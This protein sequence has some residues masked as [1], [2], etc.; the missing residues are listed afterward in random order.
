MSLKVGRYVEEEL[1]L[2][3]IEAGEVNVEWGLLVVWRVLAFM[4]VE[5]DLTM[6]LTMLERAG[7]G[8]SL[9][10]NSPT[11]PSSS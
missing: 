6:G 1:D 9:P 5:W 11:Y 7:G 2:V 3:R 8:D 10:G 4:A